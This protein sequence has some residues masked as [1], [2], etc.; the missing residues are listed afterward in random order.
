L[1]LLAGRTT[2]SNQQ[3]TPRTGLSGSAAVRASARG[4]EHVARLEGHH[5]R[6]DVWGSHG[7][8]GTVTRLRPRGATRNQY[9]PS[10]ARFSHFEF[11]RAGALG[12]DTVAVVA[13]AAVVGAS[14]PGA[15]SFLVAIICVDLLDV[16]RSVRLTRA[17]LDDAPLVVV[18]AIAIVSVLAALGLRMHGDRLPLL[19]E[20]AGSV[21][22]VTV[23]VVFAL[24]G[25]AIAYGVIRRKRAAGR[26]AHPALV[27]GAGPV[28]VRLASQLLRHPEHGLT[29][30]GFVDSPVS[31]R[32]GRLPV[33]MLGALD[34]LPSVITERRVRD[35]FVAFPQARDADLV[36]TLRAC[37]RLDCEVYVVPRLFELGAGPAAYTEHIWGLPVQRLNRAPFRTPAWRVK[38]IFDV[39]VS[40]F[41]LIV[42]IPVLV[43]TALAVRLDGGPGVLFRQKRVG[44]DGK[45]FDMLK[46]RTL[47]PAPDAAPSVWSVADR[48]RMGSV[49]RFLRRSSLDEMPQLWNVLCGQMSLVGPRPELPDYID[50]FARCYRGYDARTRVPAGVTGWAQVHDL[51]G[52]TSL[53]D[54]V[55]FDNFYIEHWSLWQD[56]KI[57]VRT[58]GSMFGMR[59]G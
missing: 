39:A 36:G 8:T 56:V 43:V 21:A 26:I 51:R 15:A 27:V 40:S 29:P 53:E 22:A 20:A 12:I 25:R 4:V 30:I 31:A 49:G 47:R 42:L 19:P 28:G 1:L 23:Y 38:R 48:S 45:C 6:R 57:V 14:A 52:D 24:T 44:L 5:T 54:R 16:K 41:L 55:A 58:V 34:D 13:S 35:V 17:V 2:H 50:N 3:S 32:S 59:G 46:F 9:S 18:S 7:M 33:P 11:R 10:G 37:D